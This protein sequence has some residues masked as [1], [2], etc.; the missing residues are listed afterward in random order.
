MDASTSIKPCCTTRRSTTRWAGTISL[1]FRAHLTTTRS[2]S[3]TW[4]WMTPMISIAP[5]SLSWYR[6]W[7][8]QK[9]H[10]RYPTHSCLSRSKQSGIRRWQ[11]RRLTI[12]ISACNKPEKVPRSIAI[13]YS[14]LAV[15]PFTRKWPVRAQRLILCPKVAL[16]CAR[17]SCKTAKGSSTSKA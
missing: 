4:S 7:A 13:N 5:S 17:S 12:T 10:L 14:Q 3:A 11:S 8:R 9:I 15:G 2:A 16:R 6:L 1:S